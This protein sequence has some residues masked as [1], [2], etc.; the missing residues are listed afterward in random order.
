MTAEVSIRGA[1]VWTVRDGKIA[2]AS[3]YPNR[4]DALRAVGLRE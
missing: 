4:E 3:F 2:R 1:A